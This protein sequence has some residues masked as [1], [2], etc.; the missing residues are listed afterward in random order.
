MPLLLI[1]PRVSSS[2]REQVA[3]VV[4]ERDFKSVAPGE[5]LSLV[6]RHNGIAETQKLARDYAG[7]A[8]VA[9]GPFPDSEAKD[10]MLLATDSVIDRVS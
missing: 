2:E 6:E 4:R 7:A 10:A 3:T 8:R 1:L 9:L 5:I